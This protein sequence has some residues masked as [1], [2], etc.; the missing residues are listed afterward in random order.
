MGTVYS[1]ITLK[2][3][4]PRDVIQELGSQGRSA[5]VV[6]SENGLTTVYEMDSDE[7]ES[8][9]LQN[10]AEDLSGC[11]GCPAF[12]VQVMD[13]HVLCYWLYDDGQ[14]VDAFA[15]EQGAQPL[16][17]KISS[18]EFLVEHFNTDASAEEVA[19]I[20]ARSDHEGGETLAVDR[21]LSLVELLDLPLCSVGFSFCD[22]D[23]GDFPE[24]VDEDDV[25]SINIE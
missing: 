19:E 25:L 22:L 4:Q 9:I 18:C 3:P 15:L 11:F 10:L 1:N 17:G 23:S 14:L 24:D 13:E 20:L 5:F 7:G 6:V 16:A 12:A 21:H 2:G 8:H